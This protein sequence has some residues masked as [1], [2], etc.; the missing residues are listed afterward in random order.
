MKVPRALGALALAGTLSLA[1]AQG[2]SASGEGITEFEIYSVNGTMTLTCDP[3]GGTHP[4]AKEACAEIDGARG[5]IAAVPRLP[6]YGCLDEWD[7]VLIGVTGRWR[8]QEV[9]FSSFE[10][11]RGCAAIRHGHIFW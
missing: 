4:Y 5:D 1:G 8:G 3:E 7:P 2:A 9:L 10:S 6:G 11:N